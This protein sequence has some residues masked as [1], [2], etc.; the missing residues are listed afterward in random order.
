MYTEVGIEEPIK[1]FAEV[2]VRQIVGRVALLLYLAASVAPPDSVNSKSLPPM[3]STVRTTQSSPI[4][5]NTTIDLWVACLDFNRHVSVNTPYDYD[6][7]LNSGPTNWGAPGG[8]APTT[9]TQVMS[10]AA[11]LL[12]Q[13]LLLDANNFASTSSDELS[14]AIWRIFG[15]SV[16]AYGNSV[17]R[18]TQ[19][20]S[21]AQTVGF[22]IPNYYVYKPL[23]A[24][25]YEKQRF[26]SITGGNH[27]V[28]DGGFTLILLGGALVGVETLQRKFSA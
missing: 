8:G 19:A 7:T 22:V 24:P 11:A 26:I 14:Y 5:I 6:R 15:N 12:M 2:C 23:T 17:S 20:L 21:N 18:A 13:E 1:N 27:Q 16:A 9:S 25:T 3:E 10:D 4:R 28:P